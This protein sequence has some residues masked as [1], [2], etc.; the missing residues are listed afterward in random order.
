MRRVAAWLVAALMSFACPVTAE[1]VPEPEGYRGPPYRAPVPA[2]LAGAT[3]VDLAQ[4]EAMQAAG[5]VLIDAMPQVARPDNLPAGTIWNDK[6]HDTI[7]GA[8]WLP[9]FGYESLAPADEAAFAATLALLSRGDS[10]HPLVF[11]CKAECW[12]SWNA[13][14]RAVA[15][16][17]RAVFWFPGGTDDWA[18]AGKDLVRATPYKP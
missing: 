3:V 15:D 14:K 9:G 18:A 1:T 4:A 2:T 5:A 8:V 7:P 10:A 11:F 12:M 17:Y 16:G 6:P 13:A